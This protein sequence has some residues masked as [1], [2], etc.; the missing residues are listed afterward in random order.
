MNISVPL[1][2]GMLPDTYGKHAPAKLQRDGH[3]FVSPPIFVEEAPAE[4]K[5]LALTFVDFDAV[6]VGGF[7]W[8]HWLACNFPPDTALI[9]ENASASGELPC[10]QGSNSD[11]SPLAGSW[12][13]PRI[14]HRYAGPYPP[15]KDHAYTLTVYALD[16]ELDL[17]EGYFLNEFRRAIRG[18]VLAKAEIE[19][20]SR[21]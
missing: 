20:V 9:P 21:A 11:W 8:I 16:I 17:V 6:P 18:H 1:E 5:S 10:V 12:T 19:V 2:H 7:C 14:I 4:A 13:D 3:P 15:D